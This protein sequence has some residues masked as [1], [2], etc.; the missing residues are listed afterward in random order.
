[1]DFG[2]RSILKPSSRVHGPRKHD[3]WEWREVVCFHS[4]LCGIFRIREGNTHHI[5]NTAFRGGGDSL[6]SY[7]TL[8]YT[9]PAAHPWIGI[10]SIPR[11]PHTCEGTWSLQGYIIRLQSPS[12]KV[13]YIRSRAWMSLDLLNLSL[14]G[15]TG[16]RGPVK[17]SNATTRRGSHPRSDDLELR[18]E[19]ERS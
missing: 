2:F 13:C 9:D 5:S 15:S 7:H 19:T 4:D 14:F 11:D 10:S 17:M 12:Q 18:P 6:K 3:G 16:I 8:S 1:M